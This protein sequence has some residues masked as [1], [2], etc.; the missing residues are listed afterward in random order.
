MR[1]KRRRASR[2]RRTPAPA[3][4]PRRTPQSAWPQRRCAV[5]R[6]DV[7]CRECHA[8]NEAPPPEPTLR[9]A[10]EDLDRPPAH[11]ADERPP[12]EQ[13]LPPAHRAATREP[14]RRRSTIREPA[15]RRVGVAEPSASDAGRVQHGERRTRHAQARLVGPPPARRQELDRNHREAAGRGQNSHEDFCRASPPPPYCRCC[16]L[17]LPSAV[18]AKQKMET[19]K[20]G[21]DDQKLDRRQAHG[22]P[23]KLHG[24][25]QRQARAGAAGDTAG[26]VP[27]PKQVTAI[28]VRAERSPSQ[29]PSRAR[30]PRR[31]PHRWSSDSD[32]AARSAGTGRYSGPR[33]S[34]PRRRVRDGEPPWWN[35]GTSRSVMSKSRSLVPGGTAD[36][37]TAAKSPRR[38]GCRTRKTRCAEGGCRDGRP[39]R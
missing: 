14:P 27:P 31:R 15:A 39:P 34:A 20:F 12:L 37:V 30:C 10:V 18:T 28:T 25:P 17:L 24:Q 26:A 7:P 1:A 29:S 13:L 32:D 38:R 36:S 19:C 2:G 4:P 5:C 6:R 11:F 9:H 35:V 22:L 8:I 33:P 3:R 21:A 23:E 16:W